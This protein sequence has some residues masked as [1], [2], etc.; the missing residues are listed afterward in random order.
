[1]LRII[2]SSLIDL[3]S[4]HLGGKSDFFEILSSPIPLSKPYSGTEISRV[5]QR[6]FNIIPLL[7]APFQGLFLFFKT[8]AVSL[9]F[10]FLGLV[11]GK[12]F[13]LSSY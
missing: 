8:A 3:G 2:I 1:M 10:Y 7:T 6:I 4:H 12:P 5:E 11:E 9:A 13:S